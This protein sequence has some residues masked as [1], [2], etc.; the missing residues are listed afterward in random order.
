M[1]LGMQV[2]GFVVCG[3]NSSGFACSASLVSAAFGNFGQSEI[4]IVQPC[5]TI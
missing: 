2:Q 5:N 4:S 1:G 3:F